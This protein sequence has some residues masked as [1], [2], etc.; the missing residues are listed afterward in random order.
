MKS[1][2]HTREAR[3]NEGSK[4]DAKLPKSK[5]NRSIEMDDPQQHFLGNGESRQTNSTSLTSNSGGNSSKNGSRASPK[6]NKSNQ[7]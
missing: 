1:D 7:S 2:A 6:H 3:V 4:Q 5:P